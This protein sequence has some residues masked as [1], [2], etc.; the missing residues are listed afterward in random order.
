[1][2]QALASQANLTQVQ[3]KAAL[4]GLLDVWVAALVKGDTVQL[5]GFGN[6]KP[7]TRAARKGIN[8]KT[9]EP[10]TISAKKAVGFS[11]AKTLKET[12]NK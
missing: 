8:P 3:A 11:A 12:L 7:K 5:A 6:F 2:I 4:E 1:M 9:K 10:I